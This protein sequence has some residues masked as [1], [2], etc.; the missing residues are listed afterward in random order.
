MEAIIIVIF[1]FI[2]LSCILAGY[3]ILWALLFGYLMFFGYALRQGH[4]PVQVLTMSGRGIRTIKNILFIFILIGMITAPSGG[5]AA[6][7]RSLFTICRACSYR[8]YSF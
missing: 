6:R 5:P 4:T 1:S 3:S 7:Y 2:L 8:R